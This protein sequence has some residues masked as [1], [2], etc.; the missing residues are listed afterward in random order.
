MVGRA[1]R[2]GGYALL[3]AWT[4]G[5][6][7]PLVFLVVNAFKTDAQIVL[8]PMSLPDA[9]HF[10]NFTR[11]LFEGTTYQ[12]MA[13]YLL[14]SIIVTGLTL[15]VLMPAASL[16][17]FGLSRYAFPGRDLIHRTVLLTLAVP[18]HAALIPVF[19]LMG[20]FGL[21]NNLGGIA[22][23]YSAF[24]LPLTVVVLRAYFDSFPSEVLDAA[25]V[26]GA[27][28][29]RLFRQIVVPMSRGSVASMAIV[30]FVGIWSELLFAF[31]ILNKSANQTMTV[32]L[33][34]FT[35]QYATDHAMVFSA[36]AAATAPT[37]LFFLLFQR[38]ITKGMT[39]GA[40]R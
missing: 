24:W 31:I 37:L 40:I 19:V 39:M 33:L 30:N 22:L 35:S 32:G 14:N 16:A 29:F 25:R 23:L 8:Y 20:T 17:A 26:D 27:S 9:P 21:R 34:G 13:P 1:V 15:I 5:Q 28:E 7:L 2:L 18:V 36:L 4:L 11:M 38:Q 6:V 10:E 12:P 3:I